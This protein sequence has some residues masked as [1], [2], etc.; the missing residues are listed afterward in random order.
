M[1]EDKMKKTGGKTEESPF[2][3]SK[4]EIIRND[5]GQFAKGSSGNPGGRPKK[6]LTI[7]LNNN[8]DENLIAG[9]LNT[10]VIE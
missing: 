7:L 10:T 3:A 9:V 2:P 5:N 4:H 8:L 6:T 1:A